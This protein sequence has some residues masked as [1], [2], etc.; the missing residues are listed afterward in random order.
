MSSLT[1]EQINALDAAAFTARLGHIFEH[2][3]WVARR[4][5]AALPFKSRDDLHRAMVAVI[6]V[7]RDEEKLELLRNHPDLAGRAALAGQLTPESTREQAGVGLDR[8]SREDYERFHALNRAYKDKFGFPFI[9]AVK[10]LTKDDI[11]AAYETRIGNDRATELETALAQVARIGALR[12]A[13][14]VR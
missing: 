5:A 3:P 12:L 13:E 10:G 7:A 2:A 1:L 8:L 6:E 11:L 4:A 14:L 9:V